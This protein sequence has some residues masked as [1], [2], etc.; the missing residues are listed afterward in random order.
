MTTVV[1]SSARSTTRRFSQVYV[2]IP[3]SPFRRDSI[4]KGLK[5]PS[6]ENMPEDNAEPHTHTG[7]KRKRE[8]GTDK[9]ETG[10]QKKKVK[11]KD[12]KAVATPAAAADANEQYPNG[13]F[14]CH[15]CVQKRDMSGTHSLLLLQLHTPANNHNPTRG[16]TVHVPRTRRHAGPALQTEVLPRVSE[17]PV[18]P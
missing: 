3:P 2:D 13:H 14:H 17:E 9:E 4:S 10:A 15:Q 12:G 7:S 8:N 16:T 1:P 6:D 5:T 11:G 18:R